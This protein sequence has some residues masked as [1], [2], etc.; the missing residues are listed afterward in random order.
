MF[1]GASFLRVFFVL[2][3]VLLVEERIIEDI[4]KGLSKIFFFQT[5]DESLPIAC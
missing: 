5:A 3:F 2:L 1:A 4:V